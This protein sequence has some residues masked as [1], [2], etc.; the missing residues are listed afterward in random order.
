MSYWTFWPRLSGFGIGMTNV[1]FLAP[2]WLQIAHLFVADSLWILLVLASSELVLEPANFSPA[3]AR[4][5]VAK[6][7]PTR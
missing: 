1:L 2:I 3:C 7:G 5:S 6:E 4:V